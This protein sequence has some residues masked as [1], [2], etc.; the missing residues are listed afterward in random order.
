MSRSPLQRSLKIMRARGYLAEPVE[1]FISGANV[2]RDLFGFADI[3]AIRDDE[4]T[5]VQS[6]S[7]SNVSAR[8]RKI[9]THENFPRVCRARIRVLVHG[10]RRNAKGRWTL[11]EIDMTTFK[12]NGEPS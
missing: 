5:T 9:A 12:Q 4:V 7:G 2:Y 11:R 6:T 1:R 8:V 10:W 3:L